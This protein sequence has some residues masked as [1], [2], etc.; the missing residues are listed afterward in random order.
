MA[1][2]DG[3]VTLNNDSNV[4]P[5]DTGASQYLPPDTEESNGTEIPEGYV[6]VNLPEV[7]VLATKPETAHQPP[8]LIGSVNSNEYTNLTQQQIQTP[9]NLIQQRTAYAPLPFPQ[10]FG[11]TQTKQLLTAID[12]AKQSSS[13]VFGKRYYPKNNPPYGTTQPNNINQ[14]YS[15]RSGAPTL[16]IDSWKRSYNYKDYSHAGYDQWET[17][18]YITDTNG[19]GYYIMKGPENAWGGRNF[20][21]WNGRDYIPFKPVGY[22]DPESYINAIAGG[23][24]E[25]GLV[26][27]NVMEFVALTMLTGNLG[28]LGKAMFQLTSGFVN[29]LATNHGDIEDLDYVDLLVDTLPLSRLPGSEFTK[30]I[31]K[32]IVKEV[33]N[34]KKDGKLTLIKN[35]EYAKA[36]VTVI[37]N[38]ILHRYL[39]QI[40]KW[41]RINSLPESTQ[42]IVEIR[43]ELIK[44]TAVLIIA[45]AF[46]KP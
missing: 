2:E 33:I 22:I 18:V 37:I 10:D 9:A 30:D 21:Y 29:Q 4:N 28:P 12:R 5:W 31:L 45:V 39:A 17:F 43:D 44:L 41:S 8:Y 6:G 3:T 26:W 23:T 14:Y 25:F 40:N 1:D 38:S 13:K 32:D 36:I 11:K 35:E 27:S 7:E 42:K 34:Y 16:N 24:G 19:K 20:S 46:E 15:T